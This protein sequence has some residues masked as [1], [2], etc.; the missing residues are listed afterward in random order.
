MSLNYK[1]QIIKN[2]N[3]MIYVY[4]H[5]LKKC[6][7]ATNKHTELRI[8]SKLYGMEAISQ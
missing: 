1:F 5:Y 7:I 2:T 4:Y 6:T 8:S 3:F